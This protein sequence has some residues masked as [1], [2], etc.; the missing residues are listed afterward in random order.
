L[1]VV[2]LLAEETTEQ[3]T[4]LLG[5][6]RLPAL[7]IPYQPQARH[8]VVLQEKVTE[9]GWDSSAC[10]WRPWKELLEVPPACAAQACTPRGV[11]PIYARL[12]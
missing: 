11:A 2:M 9:Q 8:L 4:H 6:K 1:K 7:I 5:C 3:V 10:S 12:T